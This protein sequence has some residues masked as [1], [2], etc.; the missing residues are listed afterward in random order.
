MHFGRTFP[1][2]QAI[3]GKTIF[4]YETAEELIENVKNIGEECYQNPADRAAFEKIILHQGRVVALES[5]Y[6][7]RNGDFSGSSSAHIVRDDKGNALYIEGSLID[8]NE[9]MEK[10]RP[11]ANAKRQKPRHLQ[12]SEFLAN[13]SHEI[14]TPMN[15]IIGFA[16]LAL[17]TALD[18]KQRDYIAKIEK[19]S[20]A[21]LGIINDIL[22]FSK[23]E[24]GKMSL[25]LTNF[26]LYDVVNDI[27]NILSQKAADKN[28]ELVVRVALK[29][30]GI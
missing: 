24:A 15:A 9:R 27:V 28:L 25:E 21:L 17:K 26:N 18:N 10:R 8:I 19:S 6:R 5:I 13:M 4:G 20:K 29:L 12:K 1:E 22:D 23:I 3:T 2:W 16:A 11:N 14:R 7:R 30:P